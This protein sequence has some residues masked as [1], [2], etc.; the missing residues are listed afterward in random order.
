MP[1]IWIGGV[2]IAAGLSSS[3]LGHGPAPAE[4]A[5]WLAC[6]MPW[7]A[8]GYAAGLGCRE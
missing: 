8:L 3:F 6:I 1:L 4:A 7:V 2:V 5:I